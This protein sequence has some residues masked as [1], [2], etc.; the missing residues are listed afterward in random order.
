MPYSSKIKSN[1]RLASGF[2]LVEM[3]MVA[4]VVILAIGGLIA[5]MV[6]MVGS[7]LATR[8]QTMM[9]YQSQDTLN[10]IEDDIRVS[11]EF[12]TTT[13][14]LIS[15]QGSND[16]TT[17]FSNT[18]NTLILST[19]ATTKNPADSTRELV[20]YKNQPNIC[21]SQ[22][23]F[24][25]VL[26]NKVVYFIKNGSLWRRTILPNNNTNATPDSETVC[27]APWQ[28]NSCSPGY[29]NAR[30]KT[31]DIE[32]MK[33][34]SSMAV[35]YY[36]SPASTANIGA[37]NADQALSVKVTINGSKSSAGRPLTTSQAA[38]ATRLNISVTPPTILPLQFTQQPFNNAVIPTDTNV[39]FTVTPNYSGTSIQWQRSTD[40]GVTWTNVS[41]ATSN[42]LTLATV[43]LGMNN[44]RYRAVGTLGSDIINS[45]PATLTVTLWGDIDFSSGFSNY[46]GTYAPIGYTR[47]TAG[48]VMLKGL[49]KKSSAIV[50]GE[51][52][53]TLPVGSRPSENLIFQT[54]TNSNVASRVDVYPNGDI[55]VNVGDDG[56]LSLE[57]INFIPAGTSYTRNPLT[58]VNGWVNYGGSFADATYVTDSLGRIHVQGLVRYGTIANDTQIVSNLP[59]GAR[60]DKYMHLPARSTTV[61]E[62]GISQTSG[63]VAKNTGTNGY[64]SLNSFYYPASL[65]AS[66][67]NLALQNSWVSFDGGASFTHPQ[68]TKGS[69]N[70]VRLRGLIKNGA[71][72]SGTVVTNLPA[73]FRPKDRTLLGSVCNPNVYC[74]IDVLPNGNVELYLAD[75]GWTSLDSITF[76]AEQ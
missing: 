49:I 34:V 25:Q 31:N 51:V 63:I 37:A 4:P 24:N 42:T 70:I 36:S 29:T 68:Y 17:A 60:T 7:V 61:G 55:K 39:Q 44:Y 50:S 28:Q 3:L 58:T 8:D 12:L 71:T 40:S 18:T 9:I 32:L 46:L 72:A 65:S 67:T 43:S 45:N 15:P 10:R 27:A 38:N 56:W 76:L 57:G 69:D 59:A 33:N 21:D 30:C 2:T 75:A 48:V 64:M 54:S 52:I 11:A 14:T 35:E 53:G 74:R 20:Y 16:G 62:I 5:L 73:G 66:W 1:P 23:V 26:F 6:T 47:T 19:L 41:G 13:G 22:K